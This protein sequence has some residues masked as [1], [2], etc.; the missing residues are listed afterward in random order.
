MIE[1]AN[2]PEL[3]WEWY[4][5]YREPDL[6]IA[7]HAIKKIAGQS[8]YRADVEVIKGV[9]PLEGRSQTTRIGAARFWLPR[10]ASWNTAE[11]ASIFRFEASSYDVRLLLIRV[12]HINPLDKEV[13]LETCYVRGKSTVTQ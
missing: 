11:A 3:N 1:T 12:D 4:S 2:G 7:V 8:E 6:R 10:Q 9:G 5:E 13:I